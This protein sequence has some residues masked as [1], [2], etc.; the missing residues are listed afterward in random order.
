[1]KHIR[2]LSYVLR[3]KWFVFVECCRLGIPWR[4]FVHDLSKFGRRE[5]GAYADH[6]Y[7]AQKGAKR[8]K[9]GY[10]KPTDTGDRAFDH[11]WLHHANRNDHHWQYW[12]QMIDGEEG[13][14]YAMPENAIREMVADGRGAGRAQGTPDAA[15]WYDAN[16]KKMLLTATTRTRVEKLLADASVELN[17]PRKSPGARSPGAGSKLLKAQEV[18]LL[19]VTDATGRRGEGRT[20]HTRLDVSG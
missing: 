12:T 3:H 10:Y 17:N 9:T 20:D 1:M 15:A 13:Q 8:D 7:G 16:G 6:F 5:W 18:P 11:A 19:S 14:L 4:G 2:Y